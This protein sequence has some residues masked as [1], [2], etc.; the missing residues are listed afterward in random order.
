VLWV[1]SLIDF[2]LCALLELLSTLFASILLQNTFDCA[3]CGAFG[4]SL[5]PVEV[6]PVHH[7]P[8]MRTPWAPHARQEW[9]HTITNHGEVS[10]TAGF[11]VCT[12]DVLNPNK[13]HNTCSQYL[14]NNTQFDHV[15]CRT[16]RTQ[17]A[18]IT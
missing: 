2:G 13:Q 5:Y 7:A 14:I 8:A 10:S 6:Q 17:D 18:A 11:C 12:T 1:G 4:Y 16:G 3:L 15:K 9:Q